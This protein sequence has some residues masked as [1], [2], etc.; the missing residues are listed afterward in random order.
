[1]QRIMRPGSGSSLWRSSRGAASPPVK[2][3]GRHS[4]FA[5][6]AAG[7]AALRRRQQARRY[8]VHGHR[9]TGQRHPAHHPRDGQAGRGLSKAVTDQAELLSGQN[10][11]EGS[12]FHAGVAR[13]LGVETRQP[14]A[15]LR[16]R[17]SPRAV[18][19]GQLPPQP[20]LWQPSNHGPGRR[21]LSR[22][23]E[24]SARPMDRPRPGV[25][26]RPG[27]DAYCARPAHTSLG[28]APEA[29]LRLSPETRSKGTRAMAAVNP[30]SQAKNCRA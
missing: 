8:T 30:A 1:M 4:W 12:L 23:D 18:V 9:G 13:P 11:V 19:S 25:D 10:R 15:C 6:P 5:L 7:H 17:I 29:A 22:A 24:K 14:M 2:A 26:P 20:S 3:P 21:D 27:F 16:W 28:Q